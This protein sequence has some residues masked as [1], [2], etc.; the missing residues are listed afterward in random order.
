M[1]NDGS[2]SGCHGNGSQKLKK[3]TEE[4]GH[5]CHFRN[6]KVRYTPNQHTSEYQYGYQNLPC[7]FLDQFMPILYD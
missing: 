1:C 7:S 5:F 6:T 4:N 2:F 3:H